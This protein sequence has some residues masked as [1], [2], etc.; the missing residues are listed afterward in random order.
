MGALERRPESD[1]VM[2]YLGAAGNEEPAQI[3]GIEIA[4][5]FGIEAEPDTAT[6]F[7]PCLK[8]VEKKCPFLWAPERRAF[9]PVKADHER[10]DEVEFVFEGWQQLE[11]VHPPENAL[12]PERAD[13]FRIHRHFIDIEPDGVMADPLADVEKIAGAR[14]DI[15][16]VFPPAPIKIEFL[17]PAQIDA[18]PPV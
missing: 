16:N 2:V 13:H 1:P 4:V 15:E 9:V 8:I 11:R 10:R 3:L 7:Q 17:H 18:D 6:G 5:I 14:T 12:H